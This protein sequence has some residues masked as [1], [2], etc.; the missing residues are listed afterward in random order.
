M[1]VKKSFGLLIWALSYYWIAF[2]SLFYIGFIA[3]SE[4]ILK[5]LVFCFEVT[6]GVG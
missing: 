4:C 5:G 2:A 6:E 1:C 3:D